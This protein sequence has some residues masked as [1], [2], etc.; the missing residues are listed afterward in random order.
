M[1]NGGATSP[2]SLTHSLR[3]GCPLSPLFFD[4]V[5]HPMLTLLGSEI[6]TRWKPLPPFYALQL[7]GPQFGD[8]SVRDYAVDRLRH[9]TEEEFHLVLMQ[10]VQ[11]LVYE[12]YNKSSL[13][14]LLL[15]RA[16]NWTIGHHLF[17]LVKA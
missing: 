12:P 3:Q 14:Q 15:E 1:I 9:L 6:L 13:L 17:W 11:A 5:T 8:K 16:V 4:L 2:M 10:L 7:L